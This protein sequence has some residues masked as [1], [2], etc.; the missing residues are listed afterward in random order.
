MR[1][2]DLGEEKFQESI[3]PADF[4]PL[5]EGAGWVSRA[6][7]VGHTDF[8][9]AFPCRCQQAD[10]PAGR[11]A[12][13]RRY[14]NL[15]P[16]S[17]L[18][19]AVTNTEGTIADAGSR[20]LF[21]QALTAAMRFSENPQGWLVLTGPS[22][23]GKTHLAAAIANRCIEREQTTYFIVAADLLDHLRAAYAPDNPDN[24]SVLFDQVRQVPVL[25]LD[26]LNLQ[27]ATPWAQ[28]KL[29]QV[30]NH[31]FNAQL[32]TV[33]TVRGPLERL[34]ESLRTRLEAEN[35]SHVL[36]LGQYNMRLARRLGVLNPDMLPLMTF[37]K[38][39]PRGSG[40][41]T[42]EQQA[43]LNF[44]RKSAVN[45][46]NFP[47]G[48]IMFIGPSG[49]GKT[50]LAVAIAGEIIKRGE[51]VLFAFVPEL[52]DHLRATFRPD[53]PYDYD[54][55]FEQVKTAPFLVLDDLGAASNTPWAED[56]LHQIIVYR[57]D[58]YLPTILT[59]FGP[60][61]ELEKTKP[62]IASRLQNPE[63][64][65]WCPLDVPDYRTRHRPRT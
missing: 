13:L 49:V 55:V 40:T 36:R 54:E 47:K 22:G 41:T 37:A 44:A 15:G 60:I 19:F 18:T 61:K 53:S 48:W 9:Q 27:T 29:F 24:F 51:A 45:F 38:F 58:N 11:V 17:R 30:I 59:V 7:P 1:S 50:H 25:V 28:E 39:S 52:M 6:V 34:E 35:F 57:Y 32:P 3:N 43:M 14:S 64:V 2:S 12:S 26:D 23:S 20:Q 31:R 62:R 63:M 5:C 42:V 16:L 4:C 46:A 33:F 21:K 65:E 8:G 56:K 10:S